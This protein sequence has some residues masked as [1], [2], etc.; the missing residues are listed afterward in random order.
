MLNNK[1]Y[2]YKM[3]IIVFGIMIGLCNNNHTDVYAAVSLLGTTTVKG[4]LYNIIYEYNNYKLLEESSDDED[5][6]YYYIWNVNTNTYEMIGD[7]NKNN[8]YRSCTWDVDVLNDEIYY[9]TVDEYS[10]V[11]LNK[12]N[13]EGTYDKEIKVLTKKVSSG[14]RKA[15]IN[16]ITSDSIVISIQGNEKTYKLSDFTEKKKTINKYADEKNKLINGCTLLYDFRFDKTQKNYTKIGNYYYYADGDTNAIWM[17]RGE[18]EEP[19]IIINNDSVSS[20]SSINY[21]CQGNYFYDGYIYYIRVKNSKP[22]ICRIKTDG[23]KNEKICN[24]DSVL[25]KIKYVNNGRIYVNIYKIY[26]IYSEYCI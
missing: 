12:R 3:I 16:N 8:C 26:V 5:T 18:N 11:K 22:E 15:Y 13:F 7:K 4:N 17:K 1:K 24:I 21:L 19:Q 6:K 20:D 25:E 23:S 10:M 14:I 9:T 2:L